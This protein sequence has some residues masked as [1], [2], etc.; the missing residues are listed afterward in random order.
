VGA[1]ERQARDRSDTEADP[2]GESKEA[3]Y[4]DRTATQVLGLLL[5]PQG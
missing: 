5:A 4:Y 1:V 3:Q 2:V